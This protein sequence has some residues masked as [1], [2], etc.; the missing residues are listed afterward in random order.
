MGRPVV[1]SHRRQTASPGERAALEA[2]TYEKKV[3]NDF[4]G[5]V[6]SG[7]NGTPTFFINGRR[8]DGPADF[9]DMAEVL[10]DL[11]TNSRNS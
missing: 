4:N 2:G 8:Y 6:R 11:I 5:G 1:R 7:V 9:D 3:R 10:N